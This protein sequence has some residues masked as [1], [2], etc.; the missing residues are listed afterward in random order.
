MKSDRAPG[1]WPTRILL[2]VAIIATAVTVLF[3]LW[4]AFLA[5]PTFGGSDGLSTWAFSNTI[6]FVVIAAAI[7]VTGLIW[8]IRIFR[9]P[10]DEPPP[11]RHR[12]H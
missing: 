5:P 1:Y 3:A 2:A 4:L 7:A 6:E 12:D 9:G 10:R 11:W 8:M